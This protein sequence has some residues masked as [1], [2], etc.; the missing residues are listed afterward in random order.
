MGMINTYSPQ[1]VLVTISHRATNTTHVVS[2]F[3]SDDFISIESPNS[4]IPTEKLREG[5]VTRTMHDDTD[6]KVTLKL[7]QGSASNDVLTALAKYDRANM[8]GNK[9]IFTCTI[10]DTSGRTY[11]NS[12]QCFLQ[13]PQTQGFGANSGTREWVIIMVGCNS[14]IGGNSQL[15]LE[16]QNILEAFGITIDDTWKAG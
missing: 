6:R 10:T 4:E 12:S 14:N 5:D 15:N 9:G 7:D 16:T 2:G 3:K 11:V 1:S 13:T 8:R